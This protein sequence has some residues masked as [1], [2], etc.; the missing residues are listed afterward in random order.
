MSRRRKPKPTP[1]HSVKPSAISK[2]DNAKLVASEA[3]V[4]E[5]RHVGFSGPLPPPEILAEYE[6]VIPG[7]AERLLSM[8]EENAKHRRATESTYS[9]GFVEHHADMRKIC[10][11][12]Q[13]CALL[14]AFLYVGAGGAFMYFGFP[15]SGATII[16]TGAVSMASV[17]YAADRFAR[18]R[19]EDSDQGE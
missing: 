1:P 18:Q 6:K 2:K 17:F 12:G 11:R 9:A 10:A 14:V 8:T 4:T 3:S 5:I 19:D 16:C 7:F 13:W 15:G